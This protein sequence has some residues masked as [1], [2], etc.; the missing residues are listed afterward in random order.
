M[1]VQYILQCSLAMMVMLSLAKTPLH[2]LM[3]C[4]RR[5]LWNANVSAFTGIIICIFITF[6]LLYAVVDCGAPESIENGRVVY[7]NT[8]YRSK[9]QCSCNPCYYLQGW[10]KRS[11]K[12]GGVWSKEPPTCVLKGSYS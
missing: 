12:Q 6:L 2:A 3:G 7:T 8:T 11:C 10:E 1:R 9:A 4:G 5:N